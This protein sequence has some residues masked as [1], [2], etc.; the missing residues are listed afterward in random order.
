[1][2]TQFDKPPSI[3]DLVQMA[4]AALDEIPEELMRHVRPVGI[5]VEELADDATLADLEIDSPWDL[6]GLYR[7]VPL[8]SRG[9][10]DV[11]ETPDRIMLYR[12]AIL[13]EWIEE[14]MSLPDLVRH[15][16]IH[17]I[18]HHFGWSDEEIEAINRAAD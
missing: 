7:G 8:T 4:E 5:T 15:V 10:A 2:S 1:V 18:A 12:Q 11:R 9:V 17:E 13:L 16:L 14:D 3:A 6:S